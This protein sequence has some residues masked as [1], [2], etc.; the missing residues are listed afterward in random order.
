MLQQ[1]PKT[2]APPPAV[3]VRRGPPA[4]RQCCDHYLCPVCSQVVELTD[5]RQ[6]LWHQQPEHRP[7]ELD[8]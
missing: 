3:A 7:M 5:Y 1:Y 4:L 8:D 6:V 2:D